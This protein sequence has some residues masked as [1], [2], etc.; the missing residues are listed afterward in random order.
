MKHFSSCVLVLTANLA[1][2]SFEEALVEEAL[3]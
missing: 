2:E 3:R 1:Y